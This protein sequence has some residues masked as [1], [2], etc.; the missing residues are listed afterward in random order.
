M[1]RQGKTLP[2]RKP[3][4]RSRDEDSVLLRS[5]ETLGRVIGSLQRQLDG[6]TKR[7][8][9]TAAGVINMLP[10]R[11]GKGNGS[12]RNGG[13]RKSAP[14]RARKTASAGV[15][16]TSTRAAKTTAARKTTRAKKNSRRS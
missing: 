15:K 5:A 6:A 10:A 1:A 11:K 7:V 12:T 13:I 4:D 2:A 16:R 14:A 8:S 3:R 9:G